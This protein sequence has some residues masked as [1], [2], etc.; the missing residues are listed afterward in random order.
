MAVF[1]VA[2]VILACSFGTASGLAAGER[3]SKNSRQQQLSAPRRDILSQLS[4]MVESAAQSQNENSN[5]NSLA[6]RM[7]HLIAQEP[8]A[9]AAPAPAVDTTVDAEG[10][11]ADWGTEHREG[12]YP[13]E[14][15]GKE[16]H[17]HYGRDVKPSVERMLFFNSWFFWISCGVFIVLAGAGGVK[18][19][20]TRNAA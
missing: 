12:P 14:A 11:K 17:E 7:A 9:A 10:Y 1:R 8:A 4:E 18:Y 13:P 3:K 15:E 5:S 20:Q 6:N 19:V 2:A 16:H